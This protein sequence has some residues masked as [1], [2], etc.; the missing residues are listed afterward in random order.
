ME[1][2]FIYLFLFAKSK[3]NKRTKKLKLRVHFWGQP[4]YNGCDKDLVTANINT[5]IEA[6]TYSSQCFSPRITLHI[7]RSGQVRGGSPMVMEVIE[8]RIIT[9]FVFCDLSSKFS[10]S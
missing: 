6:F 5:L 4:V 7:K 1:F 3:I 8:K 2:L 9:I 10:Q